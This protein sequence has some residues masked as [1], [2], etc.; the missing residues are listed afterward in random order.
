MN[1]EGNVVLLHVLGVLTLV[2]FLQCPVTEGSDRKEVPKNCEMA[3][4]YL[5]ADDSERALTAERGETADR[6]EMANRSG[7]AL[8]SEVTESL[9]R[10]T[11]LNEMTGLRRLATLRGLPELRFVGGLRRL[12]W[13][14][15][16]KLER[17][18]KV[19]LPCKMKTPPRHSG[20]VE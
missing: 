15:A 11:K 13:L 7:V 19:P 10:L 18:R 8:K 16:E 4:F 1:E 2:L 17:T 14:S 3:M 5:R 6:V 9:R 20:F 12:W